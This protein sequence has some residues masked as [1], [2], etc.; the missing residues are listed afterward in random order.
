MCSRAARRSCFSRSHTTAGSPSRHP[1]PR[2][3]PCATLVNRHQRT[4]KGF[5]AA[6]GPDATARTA[7]IFTEAGYRVRTE[8][9]DWALGPEFAE[10]QRQLL[11]GW[12]RAA[13]EI[14]PEQVR[15]RSPIGSP[16]ASHTSTRTVQARSRTSGTCSLRSTSL[17]NS[18]DWVIE[19]IGDLS[20]SASATIES[21]T[22]SITRSSNYPLTRLCN[23]PITQLPNHPIRWLRTTTASRGGRSLAGL[24]GYGGGRG[25]LLVHR[26]WPIRWQAGER[27][28]PGSTR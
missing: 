16:A 3:R 4:D 6:L 15:R 5:G 12:A 20:S 17:S 23:Y 28:R 9:S 18:G 24:V 13:G 21:I 10:L 1:S 25:S 11:A 7:E 14:A 27:R 19:L 22:Q 26:R 8:P 2:T